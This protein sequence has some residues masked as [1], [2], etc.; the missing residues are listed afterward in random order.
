MIRSY[1][2]AVLAN[3]AADEV[4]LPTCPA[5]TVAAF[6]VGVTTISRRPWPA[7]AVRVAANVVVLPA[8]AAPSTTTN[9]ALPARAA[10]AAS[11]A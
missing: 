10:T 11:W 5:A 3:Q 2:S 1:A 9:L 6:N 4:R 7:S 8:P